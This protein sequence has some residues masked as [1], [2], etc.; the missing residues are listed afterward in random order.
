[1]YQWNWRTPAYDGKFGAVHGIDVSA[2]FHS[3]RDGFFAGSTSGKKMAD[4]FAS[5][6]AAFVRTGNPSNEHMPPWKPYDD[7]NRAV[8]IFDDDTR[9]DLNPRAEIRAFWDANPPPPGPRG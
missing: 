9:Q 5:A 8:M 3:Y 1:M 6:W 7:A 4:R 2:S